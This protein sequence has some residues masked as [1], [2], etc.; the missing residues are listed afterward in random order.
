V[1]Y[2]VTIMRGAR[3]GRLLGPYDTKEEAD[4]RV[5]D[6]RR[7]AAEADPFAAFD[8]FGVTGMEGREYPHGK[9]NGMLAAGTA[10]TARPEP[11]GSLARNPVK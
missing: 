2:Y 8:A 4:Q 5:P 7:L 6:A 1:K 11:I 3:V 9:L 10:E